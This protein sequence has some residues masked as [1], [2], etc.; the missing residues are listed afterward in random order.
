VTT[1]KV[2]AMGN[3]GNI[4]TSLGTLKNPVL[5]SSSSMSGMIMYF[6]HELHGDLLA[7]LTAVFMLFM[8][9]LIFLIGLGFYIYAFL[10]LPSSTQELVFLQEAKLA[11]AR[12]SGSKPGLDKGAQDG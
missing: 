9:V 12:Q 2:L 8:A 6:F 7:E 1:A 10:R 4:L 5:F 3:I 11:V